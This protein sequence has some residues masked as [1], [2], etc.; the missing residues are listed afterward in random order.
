[1]RDKEHREVDFL[2]VMENKPEY[3]IE[4]KT[5]DEQFSPHLRY[6]SE[7]V[8][9]REAIQ[10]VHKLDKPS[11]NKFGSVQNAAAWLSGLEA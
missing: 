4:V 1:L 6:F 8:I 9:H 11:T 10:L 2:T 3:M 5:S 7:R